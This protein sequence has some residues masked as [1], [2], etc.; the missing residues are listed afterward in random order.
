[1]LVIRKVMGSRKTLVYVGMVAVLC[2]I[3]GL[4]FGMFVG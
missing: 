4:I 2:T 1:M 3:A